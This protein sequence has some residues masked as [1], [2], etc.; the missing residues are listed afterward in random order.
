MA[1]RIHVTASLADSETVRK[2]FREVLG[3][4]FESIQIEST[5]PWNFFT[6]SVWGVA[7]SKLIEGLQRTGQIGLQATTSDASRWYLTLIRPSQSPLSFL[8]EFHLFCSPGDP[9]Q[10]VEPPEPDEIDPRLAFL[11][12]D[13]NPGS[14]REW[15][16]FDSIADDYASMGAPID[17]SFRDRVQ[18]MTYGAALNE[19]QQYETA[20]LADCL[21]KAGIE[22]DR[23]EL[24][25]ALLWR[26][27]TERE[28]HADIGNLP[29]V[30]LA[31]GLR[32]S[33][34]DFFNPA[35]DEYA[36]ENV[37]SADDAA[38]DDSEF[39]DIEGEFDDASDDESDGF[40][41][42]SLVDEDD[43]DDE[44]EEISEE[45]QREIEEVEAQM[46]EMQRQANRSRRRRRRGT[47]P[48]SENVKWGPDT[49]LSITR[50]AA[51]IHPLTPIGGGGVDVGIEELSLLD[52]FAHAVSAGDYPPAVITITPPP[53]IKASDLSVSTPNCTEIEVRP[54]DGAWLVGAKSLDVLEPS[55]WKGGDGD[56]F[57]VSYLGQELTNLLRQPPDG[58]RLQ[59]EFAAAAQPEVCLRFFGFIKGD[60][61]QITEGYPQLDRQTFEDALLLARQQ[62]ADEYELSSDEEGETILQA[63]ERDGYLYNMGVTRQGNRIRCEHDGM[64]YV[65]RLILRHRFGHV[66]NFGPALKHVEA[67][68][69]QRR[70][71]EQQMRR[72]AAT[73]RR[74]RSPPLDRKQVIY[75][76]DVSI[77]WKANMAAWSVLT[78][79]PREAFD[80]AMSNL[81]FACLGDFVCKKVRDYVQR[82][83]VSPDQ[84]SYALLLAGYFGYVGQEFVSHFDNGAHLTTSTSW[85]AQCHPEIEVYAQHCPQLTTDAL[86][87][88]HG[89]GIGRFDSHKQT[90]PVLLDPSLA[91]LCRL[92]DKMLKRMSTVESNLISFETI[93]LSES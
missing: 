83:F 18:G 57:L 4:A 20:R 62:E 43:D 60:K 58:T 37:D 63:A 68:W 76:G 9:D 51:S 87:E 85:L 21:A 70:L 24:L 7:S 28:S 32:G 34:A 47:S 29:R 2:A 81:G 49:F 33:I 44:D 71:M 25:D 82:V 8:Y 31:L 78:P 13:P 88:R 66:W 50:E 5:S 86:Y 90:S 61:W 17:E 16:Q 14:Q 77:Y 74:D 84:R 52:F 6:T 72:Q 56:D 64:G 30:L 55:E 79:E 53:G 42:E 39:D 59:V 38:F 11:E 89:W 23:Q 80:N 92:F 1:V 73:L 65:A 41:M 26:S 12:P 35:Q 27:T 69:Q 40:E 15:S 67:K 54:E 3:Q 19:F 22:F 75:R 48:D 46:R 10:T 93:D 45:D 36:S 91:G